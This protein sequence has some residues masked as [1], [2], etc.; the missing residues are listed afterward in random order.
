MKEI[1]APPSASLALG[2]DSIISLN[3]EFDEIEKSYLEPEED[4]DEHLSIEASPSIFDDNISALV[5]QLPAGKI[6]GLFDT[7]A[8]HH[9]FKTLEIFDTNSV[10]AL[11]E[12]N[13]QL[14]LAG[15]KSS[16]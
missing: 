8:T 9:M 14:T 5:S 1:S 13:C 11:P 6:W 15:G 16:L 12:S 4:E 3:C 7:G 2:A 10:K